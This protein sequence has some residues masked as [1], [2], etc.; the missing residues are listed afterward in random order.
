[1]VQKIIQELKQLVLLRSLQA[2]IF[3]I[4]LVVGVVPGV[5]MRYGIL[6]NYE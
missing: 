1:M 2:R 5:L 4:I 3:L 6:S